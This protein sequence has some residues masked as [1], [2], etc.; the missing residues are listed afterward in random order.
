MCRAQVW[1]FLCFSGVLCLSASASSP[2]QVVTPAEYLRSLPAPRFRPGHTLPP[3]TRF[4]WTLPF[5]ARVELAERW[6]YCLEFGGYATMAA[7]EKA[8]T[9]PQSESGRVLALAARDPARYPLAVIVARDLPEEIPEGAWTCGA[10]GK[11][12]EGK[13]IWSPEAP[14]WVFERA[15]ELRAAPLRRIRER[16][17]IRVVLNGGEYALSVYGHHGKYWEQ[18]PRIVK[19]KGA[20]SW[21]E[22]VSE[23]KARQEL[24][25][26]E[27]VRAAVPDRLFY[28]YY[29]TGG[30]THRNRYAGWDAWCWDYRW[31]QPVSDIPT[32]EAYY[33]HFNDGWTGA[34]DALTQAL[35]AA[36]YEL[37]FGQPLSY[38]WLCAGWPRENLGDEHGLSDIPRYMGF[39][40]CYYTAGM[41]GGNAGYYAY[42]KGGFAASFPEGDP[43]HWLQQMVA[44]SR[45]HAL[46][47]HLEAFLRDGDLLPGP[48]RHR[49]TKDQPAYELPTGD[50]GARVLGR[51]RRAA[52]EWLLTAWAADGREREVTVTVE[53]LGSV[54]LL[55]R[56]CGSVYRATIK[57]G[58]PA[59]ELVDADGLMPTENT[60]GAAM[61]VNPK[62]PLPEGCAGADLL[63]ENSLARGAA[64]EQEWV[65]EGGGLIEWTAE[66]MR[67]RPKRYTVT[68]S[69][70]ETDH[71][72][73]WLKRDFP[74]DIRVE[75]EFRFP[76]WKQSPNGLAILF[77]C[78]RG[79]NGKDLFDPTLQQR[80]GIFAR[81]HSGDINCYHT[82]YFAGSRGSANLRKNAGFHLVASGPD[83][84]AQGGPEK[85]H[86]LSLTRFGPL[87]SLVVD[88]VEC[89]RWTDDGKT[90]GP[91]LGGGKIGLRQ[92][93][94]L[95]YGDYR[96]LR[97]YGLRRL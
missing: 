93:N 89:F 82:S 74:P 43:P 10:D 64:N 15:G 77:S 41:I 13:R 16:A 22:Y 36:G 23:Q 8:L 25:I 48:T 88:D 55:A 70:V 6:G 27:A 59:L 95:L 61:A 21:Y 68:R 33:K 51:K 35:N 18:D 76:D 3:L 72:T 40:K 73:C 26:S 32:N 29:T 24:I 52:A 50:A 84:V 5:D 71:F 47:S 91:L 12:V 62:T 86:S 45:V 97:V 44:L 83:L 38:N 9:D 63:Y 39:L 75:W 60:K 80:D 79:A 28:V 85:W 66:G 30:G 69:R 37:R 20:R 2:A 49:W 11:P 92:Q 54:T 96:N 81:Y 78:A 1:I 7:V 94:D 34:N 65:M 58:T 87:I 19:A 31:M 90:Y 4:G 46:F 17:P 14:D 56:P 67:L 53:G 42:P 57:N